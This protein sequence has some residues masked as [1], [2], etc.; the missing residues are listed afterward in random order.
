M[1]ATTLPDV[2][3]RQLSGPQVPPLS[4]P[5]LLPFELTVLEVALGEVRR[6]GSAS[7]PDAPAAALLRR[8]RVLPLAS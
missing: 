7:G 6:A 2:P 4:L 3:A 1:S 5:Q 8:L